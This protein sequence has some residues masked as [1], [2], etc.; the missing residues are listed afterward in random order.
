MS[1]PFW[2][3]RFSISTRQQRVALFW[4][5]ELIQVYNAYKG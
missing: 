2:D 1:C 5:L 3:I 4:G